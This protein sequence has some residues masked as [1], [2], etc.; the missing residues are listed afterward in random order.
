MDHALWMVLLVT[1]ALSG[2]WGPRC[3]TE[4]REPLSKDVASSKAQQWM[5]RVRPEDKALLSPAAESAGGCDSQLRGCDSHQGWSQLQSSRCVQQSS[6]LGLWH[7]VQSPRPRS[8]GSNSFLPSQRSMLEHLPIY[9]L[10]T[11]L[12]LKGGL[13]TIPRQTQ[14]LLLENVPW[15]KVQVREMEGCRDSMHSDDKL[16]SRLQAFPWP[17]AF[18]LASYVSWFSP[19]S[20][21]SS[22]PLFLPPS[23]LRT[24]IRK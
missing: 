7:R 20:L 14:A 4:R 16:L 23:S 6:S 3:T 17:L 12:L 8:Q 18:L 22:T 19:P 1:P 2:L 5:P 15:R 10:N 21:P 13:L 24:V 9:F 11:H